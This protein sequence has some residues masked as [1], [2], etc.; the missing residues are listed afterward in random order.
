[1]PKTGLASG[2]SLLQPHATHLLT[3]LSSPLSPLFSFSSSSPNAHLRAALRCRP[4]PIETPASFFFSTLGYSSSSLTV[5]FCFSLST[6][7]SWQ[8][9]EAARSSV[10]F[11]FSFSSLCSLYPH[12]L[13]SSPSPATAWQNGAVG[14][15]NKM[16]MDMDIVGLEFRTK[17]WLILPEP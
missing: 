11:L 6:Y 15:V 2:P 3:N 9:S 7:P 5:C 16:D 1:M 14:T 10:F 17:P 8:V 4:H 13:R 12:P